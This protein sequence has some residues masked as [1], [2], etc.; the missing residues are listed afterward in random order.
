[1][2]SDYTHGRSSQQNY[3][4][5][6]NYS[7]NHSYSHHNSHQARH[8]Y[9]KDYS[10]TQSR[11][12][13]QNYYA[14]SRSNY[15]ENNYATKQNYNRYHVDNRQNRREQINSESVTL[16]EFLWV[17]YG[18][19]NFTMSTDCISWTMI[20]LFHREIVNLE[21]IQHQQ[22]Q[23]WPFTVIAPVKHFGNVP[24]FK[25]LSPEEVR[26]QYLESM[27]TNTLYDFVSDENVQFY[28]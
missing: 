14:N 11:H 6:E 24:G 23:M 5:N 12:H 21:L 28:G 19:R 3:Y 1:M 10:Q 4:K 16:A 13:T 18:I 27:S 17:M 2:I 26:Y 15:G 20:C 25:D 22:S 8:N 9:E 7:Q